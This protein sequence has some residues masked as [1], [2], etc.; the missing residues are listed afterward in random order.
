VGYGQSLDLN[1]ARA[2]IIEK[3]DDKK[4]GTG[5]KKYYLAVNYLMAFK[6]ISFENLITSEISYDNTLKEIESAQ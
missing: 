3:K 4:P 5:Y 2:F 6:K 1:E